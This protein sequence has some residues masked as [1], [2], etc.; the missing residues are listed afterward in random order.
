[1]NEKNKQLL[2]PNS[3]PTFL[4][5]I[6]HCFSSKCLCRFNRYLSCFSMKVHVFIS[7]LLALN[8]GGIKM[9]FLKKCT[10]KHVQE[11]S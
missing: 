6:P 1:M 4:F 2:C 8:K 11:Y 7:F 9:R 10:E 3:W 5:T